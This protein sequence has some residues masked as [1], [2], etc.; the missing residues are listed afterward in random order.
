MPD[1]ESFSTEEILHA[2]AHAMSWKDVEQS[3]RV[4]IEFALQ[5]QHI[6]HNALGY[7]PHVAHCMPHE[8]FIRE[9]AKQIHFNE[10]APEEFIDQVHYHV[11]QIRNEEYKR[12]GW[13]RERNYTIEEYKQYETYLAQQKDITRQRVERLLGFS[14]LL[15]Y[16]LGA[17]LALREFAHHEDFKSAQWQKFDY[18]YLSIIKYEEVLFEKGEKVADEMGLVKANLTYNS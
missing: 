2:N 1:E 9:L 5:A 16:S 12:S 7:V 13:A 6:I 17:E 8:L 10:I 11:K 3:S 15:L 4:L 18:K 14:P